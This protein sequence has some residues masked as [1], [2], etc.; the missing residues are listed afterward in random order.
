MT[1][2]FVVVLLIALALSLTLLAGASSTDVVRL[3]SGRCCEA[4]WFSPDGNSILYLRHQTV[5]EGPPGSPGPVTEIT[6]CLWEKGKSRD[7][8]RIEPGRQPSRGSVRL[9]QRYP[10]VHWLEGGRWLLVVEWNDPDE[11]AGS[12]LRL[13]DGWKT[14]VERSGNWFSADAKLSLEPATEGLIAHYLSR[15][16]SFRAPA[17]LPRDRNGT[18][19]QWTSLSRDGLWA[20][21]EAYR[22][23]P[24]DCACG[25]PYWP[26]SVALCRLSTHRV[27]LLTSDDKT[28][29]T[30]PRFSP[31]AGHI[32]YVARYR[33]SEEGDT[34]TS[35]PKYQ[36]LRLLTPD[37]AVRERLAPEAEHV[38]A[39]EWLDNRRIVYTNVHPVK[40]PAVQSNQYWHDVQQ[41]AVVNTATGSRTGL[42]A[43]DFHHRYLDCHGNRYLVAE[44]LP[45]YGPWKDCK[46]DLF[47]ITPRG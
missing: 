3:T 22:P 37:G 23:H 47:V 32:A 41:L 19:Y 1:G 9:I 45:G 34:E 18:Y 14:R 21:G 31:D 13:A 40:P 27:T 36:H 17:D 30:Q 5:G 24:G 44:S 4:G 20:L 42:T 25:A 2:R 35:E 10:K 12:L 11:A 46:A 28:A 26:R 6:V 43:G 33:L 8:L 15:S 38:S 39:F 7:L 16:Q 29:A